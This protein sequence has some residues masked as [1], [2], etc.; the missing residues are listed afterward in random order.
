MLI[1]N[2]CISYGSCHALFCNIRECMRLVLF[3]LKK[4]LRQ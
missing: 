4:E 3:M 1:S 2:G